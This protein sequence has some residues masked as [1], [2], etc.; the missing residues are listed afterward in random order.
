MDYSSFFLIL[1]KRLHFLFLDLDLG[2]FN[3]YF[4][5]RNLALTWHCF[6]KA[7][8]LTIYPEKRLFSFLELFT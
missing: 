8:N 4:I 3:N 5:V 6:L 7:L 2:I 1:A